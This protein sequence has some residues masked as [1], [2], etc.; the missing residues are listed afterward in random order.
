MDADLSRYGPYE[1]L[2]PLGRGGMGVVYRAR[3]RTTGRVAALKTVRLP[4]A[5]L[6]ESIRR[7]ILALSRIRHPG[8]VRILEEGVCEGIPWY[9]MELLRGHGLRRWMA[10]LHAGLARRVP[11]DISTPC[12]KSPPLP[13]WTVTLA[14]SSD[15]E[16]TVDECG[17]TAPG[18]A[19]EPTELSA[20]RRHGLLP[21]LTMVRRLCLALA[22]VHGEGL[23]HRDLKPDNIVIGPGD[24]PVLVDFGLVSPFVG[25]AS[26]EALHVQSEFVGTPEY[27]APEQIQGGFIDARADLYALGCVLYELVTGR[28]P[29][30]GRSPLHLTQAHLAETPKPPSR[31][32]PDLPRALEE[33]IFGL[34]EKRPRDRIGFAIDVAAALARLGAA[35]EPGANSPP[36]RPYL[37]R[38]EFAGR[39]RPM[40]ALKRHL[41]R[42]DTGKGALI[43]VGGESGVGKTRLAMEFGRMASR[44]GTRVL[45]GQC[46]AFAPDS[47]E[48]LQ[49]SPPLQALAGPL[50]NI[51]DHCRESG[52]WKADMIFGEGRGVLASYVPSLRDLPGR[53]PATEPAELPHKA[54]HFRL[55]NGLTELFRSFASDRKLLLILDDLQW[56]DELTLHWLEHLV[57]TDSLEKLPLLLIGTYRKEGVPRRLDL[58]RNAAGVHTDNLPRLDEEATGEI[59]AD[60]LAMTRPPRLFVRFLQRRSLGNPF[61]VSAYLH[62]ALAK[63][64]L[65]RD[66]AGAWQVAEPRRQFADQAIYESLPVPCLLE[67]LVEHQ[68]AALSSDARILLDAAAVLGRKVDFSLLPPVSGLTPTS[69]VEAVLELRGRHILEEAEGANLQ[70]V[71]DHFREIAYAGLDDTRKGTAHFA[72]AKAMEETLAHDTPGVVVEIAQHWEKAGKAENAAR[73]Y[74]E[75]GQR[76]RFGFALEDAARFYRRALELFPGPS[77]E[78]LRA[79]LDFGAK[80]LRPIGRHKEARTIVEKALQQARALDAQ[81]A[82]VEALSRLALL[83]GDL[84]NVARALELAGQALEIQNQKTPP[85]TRIETYF[86]QGVLYRTQSRVQEARHFYERALE[87]A[88]QHREQ[89]FVCQILTEIS[90]CHYTLGDLEEARRL[91]TQAL[92]IARAEGMKLLQLTLTNNLACF[93]ID[94][95][96]SGEAENMFRKVL[97]LSKDM[98]YRPGEA[99]AFTNLGIIAQERGKL[100]RAADYYR[101]SLELCRELDTLPNAQHVL[102][103]LAALRQQQGDLAEARKLY[104]TAL[105]FH[106]QFHELRLEG[107]CLGNLAQLEEEE[108][109]LDQLEPLFQKSLQR[110][111][112]VGDSMMEGRI[113]LKYAM[114][115]RRALGKLPQARQNL[116]RAKTLLEAAGDRGN[117]GICACERAFQALAAENDCDPFLQRAEKIRRELALPEESDLAK[118]IAQVRQARNALRQRRHDLLFRGQLM[119]DLPPGLQKALGNS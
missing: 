88:R 45:T 5:R 63:G 81:T 52:P 65:W 83:E 50:Q 2:E 119:E 22:F 114:A 117:L 96:R 109:N 40:T 93:L 33:L 59:V 54:A 90:T 70:F 113:L 39:K 55:M 86:T 75:A 9:A 99:D 72:A 115:L 51:I 106:I 11:S 76:A 69:V 49:G 68:F 58:L 18:P 19:A 92:T 118:T 108:G 61:F 23:V 25:E 7:E 35:V 10:G 30:Q 34:L 100:E 36:P 44:L 107:S 16:K 17:K 91:A 24:A 3:H 89:K 60:M 1:I 37:Y 62:V 14:T 13:W 79:F 66:E 53:Q 41:E 87:L 74:L 32:A 27:V 103:N 94:C 84:G 71:H 46:A 31:W 20:V 77:T 12:Q 95:G 21:V 15:P 43:F 4:D 73:R 8:V 48:T 102:L 111:R 28:V 82:Q 105:D 29:F 64:V 56:A 78:T 97:Q 104:Q 57:R 67:E 116:Q 38:A 98:G 26:R 42:L 85:G 6:L 112:Q 80:V 101:R 110:L 47:S